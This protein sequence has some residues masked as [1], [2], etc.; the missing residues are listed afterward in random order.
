MKFRLKY[1]LHYIQRYIYDLLDGIFTCFGSQKQKDYFR[2]KS[3]LCSKK[4]YDILMSWD[5]KLGG[6]A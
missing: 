5:A 6:D 1:Y 2:A 4:I 3:M